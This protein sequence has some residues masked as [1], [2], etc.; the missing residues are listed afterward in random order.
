MPLYRWRPVGEVEHAFSRFRN[1]RGARWLTAMCQLRTTPY[2]VAQSEIYA[3]L[4]DG[5]AGRCFTCLALTDGQV[6]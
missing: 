6:G 5:V 4:R 2:V 1:R 3:K